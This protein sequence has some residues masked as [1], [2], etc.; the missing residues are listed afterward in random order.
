MILLIYCIER[1]NKVISVSEIKIPKG[2]RGDDF[3]R[4]LSSKL[5]VEKNKLLIDSIHYD[6]KKNNELLFFNAHYLYNLLVL[7]IIQ[8]KI[9]YS[10]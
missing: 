4:T 1:G 3:S 10:Y 6:A 5:L 7:R 8:A 9:N 2:N